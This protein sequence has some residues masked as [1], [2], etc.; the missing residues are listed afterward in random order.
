MGRDEFKIITRMLA[1]ELIL[2]RESEVPRFS[3]SCEV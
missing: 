3:P 2:E 1:R